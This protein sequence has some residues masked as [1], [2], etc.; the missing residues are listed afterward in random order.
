MGNKVR[1]TPLSFSII[2]KS[3]LKP[4]S[5]H[6]LVSDCCL[7]STYI[8]G[9]SNPKHGSAQCILEVTTYFAWAYSYTN[10]CASANRSSSFLKLFLYRLLS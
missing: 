9:V 5:R 3:S 7:F 4:S 8:T 10:R 6:A 1:N 2:L